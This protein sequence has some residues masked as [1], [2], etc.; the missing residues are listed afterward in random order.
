[1]PR[2]RS[3]LDRDELALLIAVIVFI[4][5]VRDARR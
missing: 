1:M 5:N 2:V 4:V 3:R